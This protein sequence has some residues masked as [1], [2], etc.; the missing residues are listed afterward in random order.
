[1]S[2][3]E[4][5]PRI[6]AVDDEPEIRAMLEDYL[7]G[8]GFDVYTAANGAAMREQIEQQPVDLVMLDINRTARSTP[9]TAS[10]SS[11]TMTAT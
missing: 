8:Q 6:L 10:S 4:R 5:A 2:K 9:A 1:M 7:Q 11:A 3:P